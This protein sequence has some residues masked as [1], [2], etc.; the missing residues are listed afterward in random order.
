M[1]KRL[2]LML[3]ISALLLSG[4]NGGAA[5]PTPSYCDPNLLPVLMMVED[6]LYQAG[7]SESDPP[8]QIG[9]SQILGYISKSLGNEIPTQ[10]GEACW[11]E[12]GAPYA[13]CPLEEYPEGMVALIDGQWW[14]FLPVKNGVKPPLPVP[15][16]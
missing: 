10:N 14:I 11:V 9:D 1:I 2:F 6:T 3:L 15:S 8:I 5:D 12:V 16:P 4:C 7:G 13:R